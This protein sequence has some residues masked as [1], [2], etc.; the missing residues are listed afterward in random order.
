[1][2]YLLDVNALLALCLTQ[3]EQNNTVNRWQVAH[4]G[5]RFATC[6]TTE[7]G[8]VRIAVNAR[9]LASV[10]DGVESLRRMKTALKMPFIVDDVEISA[11]PAYVRR[12]GEVTD[13]HL[14]ALAKRH[15]ARLATLDKGIPGAYLID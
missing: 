5:D 13:G 8:F 15:G 6:A 3:H 12:A 2:I 10:A 4:Q 9:Y 1:M 11:L 14:L 7:M